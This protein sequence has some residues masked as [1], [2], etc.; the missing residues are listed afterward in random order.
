MNKQSTPEVL[1]EMAERWF[2]R[3]KNG[4]LDREFMYG[5][6]KKYGYVDIHYEALTTEDV[7]KMYSREILSRQEIKKTNPDLNAVVTI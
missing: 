5:I 3:Y 1:Q 6:M 7:T 2:Y 4:W